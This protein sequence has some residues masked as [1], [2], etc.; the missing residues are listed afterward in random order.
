[1]PRKSNWARLVDRD[2]EAV[3]RQVDFDLKH[4]QLVRR[5]VELNPVTSRGASP[6]CSGSPAASAG[7]ALSK[8][9]RQTWVDSNLNSKRTTSMR[10]YTEAATLLRPALVAFW[11][12]ASAWLR[13]P[14]ETLTWHW[15]WTTQGSKLST[16]RCGPPRD[17]IEA[18]SFL[19]CGISCRYDCNVVRS[20]IASFFSWTCCFFSLNTKNG[21]KQRLPEPRWPI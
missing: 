7:V 13:M 5:S 15:C 10:R 20:H 21:L 14:C 19:S 2:R 17:R 3:P 6:S 16:G 9:R 12:L 4:S 1:M 8:A 18:L 11:C